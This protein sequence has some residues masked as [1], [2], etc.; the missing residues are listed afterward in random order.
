MRTTVSER[1]ASNPLFIAWG[2]FVIRWRCQF[3]QLCGSTI[4]IAAI[5]SKLRKTEVSNLFVGIDASVL[6]DPL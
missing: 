3:A 2:R 6:N 5:Q 4:Y 1:S